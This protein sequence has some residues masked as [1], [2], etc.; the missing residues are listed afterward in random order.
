MRDTITVMLMFGALSLAIAYFMWRTWRE[1]NDEGFSG[2]ASVTGIVAFELMM[3]VMWFI[4][5][6]MTIGSVMHI[7]ERTTT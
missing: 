4:C 6:G 1:W 7:Y 3:L 2:W 5:V